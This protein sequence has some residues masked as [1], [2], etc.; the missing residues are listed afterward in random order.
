[1]TQQN[2]E[3]FRKKFGP[4]KRRAGAEVISSV[5]LIAIT[6]VGAVILT[7]FLDETFVA[8]GTLASGSDNTIKSIKL[9][10]YDARDGANLMGLTG[11]N[12]TGPTNLTLC[13]E[14]CVGKA[15][16]SPVSNNATEFLVIQVENQS[17]NPIFLEDIWLGNVIHT[18]DI[19]TEGFTLN[20]VS[21]TSGDNYPSDGRFSVFPVGNSNIPSDYTQEDN[22]INSGETVNIL[23]KLDSTNPDIPLGKTIR[24]QFDIGDS[25]LSEFLIETGGAQ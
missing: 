14:S 23:I 2:L 25:H 22:K 11:L 20:P 15:N 24:T 17:V 8:G 7:T 6:V 5:L 3:F 12:N 19:A 10:S 4:K 16:T 13:R 1:M 18:W 9:I 21:G